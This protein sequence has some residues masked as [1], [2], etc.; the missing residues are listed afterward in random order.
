MEWNKTKQNTIKRREK[1]REKNGGAQLSKRFMI[2]NEQTNRQE[3]V[4]KK[5]EIKIYILSFRFCIFVS[6]FGIIRSF[7]LVYAWLVSKCVTN[8]WMPVA[9]DYDCVLLYLY[10]WNSESERA[11]YRR[12]T[13]YSVHMGKQYISM[14]LDGLRTLW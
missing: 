6:N 1:E 7:F 10:Q 8:D 2:G 12:V 11:R 5:H 4:G 14:D 3:E 13:V 9:L